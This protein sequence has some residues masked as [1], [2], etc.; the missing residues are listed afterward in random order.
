MKLK[1][2]IQKNRKSSKLLYSQ[3]VYFEIRQEVTSRYTK[4]V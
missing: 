3:E 4:Y 2:F 1:T